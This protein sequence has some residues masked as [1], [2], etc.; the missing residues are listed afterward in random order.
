MRFTTSQTSFKAGRLSPKL[1]NRIDTEQYKNGASILHAMKVL[2][3]GGV[4]R[5][6][7]YRHININGLR[8]L[9]NPKQ[10][11][12]TVKGTPISVF[13]YRDDFDNAIYA[14]RIKYPYVFGQEQT[15]TLIPGS[16][17]VLDP[18]LF[19]WAI[20]KNKL[21]LAHYGGTVPPFYIVFNDNG[22]ISTSYNFL[23]IGPGNNVAKYPM[24]D[25]GQLPGLT[26]GAFVGGKVELTSTDPAVVSVL[27][28]N[29]QFY[30][31][32]IGKRDFG[33]GIAESVVG[34]DFFIKFANITNGILAQ[35]YQYF[36]SG[37][38]LVD[39]FTFLGVTS[40]DQWS[41]S[42]WRMNNW[43]K[44]VTSH[45][46]RVVFGGTP[47]DPLTIFGSRVNNSEAFTQQKRQDP[48]NPKLTVASPFGSILPTDPYV[49]TA[50]SKDD[51]TITFVQSAQ[52]LIIGTDTK[53]YVA[54]GGDTILS[55]LSVNIKPYTAQGSIALGSVSIGQSVYYIA[56]DGKKLFKFKFSDANG[57][58]VSQEV[59]LLFSDLLEKDR[60]KF[61]FWA[62]HIS[63]LMVLMHSGKLY[64]IMDNEQAGT[65]AFWDTG[66]TGVYSASFVRTTTGN[67]GHIGDHIL[68]RGLDFGLASF[69]Q[70]Y[71]LD[72]I[73]DSGIDEDI[74]EENIYMYLDRATIISRISPNNF[75]W[76]GRAIGPTTGGVGDSYP[77][78]TDI[79][80]VGTQL[81]VLDNINNFAVSY[82]TV[83]ALVGGAAFSPLPHT[84]SS[85]TIGILP[86]EAKVAT[87]PIEAGQQWGS[88]QM[89]IKNIDTIGVR[90]YKTY[91]YEISSNGVTWQPKN[92]SSNAGK[93]TTGR[94]DTKYD[95]SPNTDQIV[96]LRNAKAE[97]FCILGI[98]MRGVS[99]DG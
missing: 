99:N 42:M 35:P 18:E 25:L 86:R 17:E 23:L 73:Y 14:T 95:A 80:P 44:T 36:L 87:M 1:V 46:S 33:A 91:S 81:I 29:F 53:E 51:S 64:A 40:I 28:N 90:H 60:I 89:G 69:E 61:V 71:Y 59:S 49:F 31:E 2:P 54:G 83:P 55:A 96:Y 76:N 82:F 32:A 16:S 75:D 10:I 74:V 11:S 27:Q 19:D 6:K 57:S 93:A 52:N 30:L 63:S 7:G 24:T 39:I 22:D 4:E 21:V 5:T 72:G 43:P 78:E 45:E 13:I 88:A 65:S 94:A 98:N 62:A 58:F 8:E 84:S 68:M 48:L 15:I 85:I 9:N 38:N 50:A 97:P 67:A 26:R 56:T 3:E 20:S 37:G 92:V 77:I 66:I 34:S 47:S 12:I 70:M 41:H 79:Y